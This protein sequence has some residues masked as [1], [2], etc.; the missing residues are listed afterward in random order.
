MRLLPRLILF[1]WDKGNIDKNIAKHK[2]KNE[3]AEEVFVNQ[4]II[5]LKDKKHSE[6]ESRFMVLGQTDK[7]RPLSIFFTIRGKEVRIISA[8]PMGRKERR[9]YEKKTKKHSPL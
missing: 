2:I 1:D 5:L 4:P 3:E 8:R 7:K 9:L 6:K